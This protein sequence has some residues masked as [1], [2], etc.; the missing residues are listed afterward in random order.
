MVR[1]LFKN[2]LNGMLA[3][4]TVVFVTRHLHLLDKEVI[5]ARMADGKILQVEKHETMLE[6]DPDYSQ[7]VESCRLGEKKASTPVAEDMVALDEDEEL[8]GHE[9]ADELKSSMDNLVEPSKGSKKKGA[10]FVGNGL[11]AAGSYESLVSLLDQLDE[12]VNEMEPR[13]D[14]DDEEQTLY[15]KADEESMVDHNLNEKN[16]NHPTIQST[17]TKKDVKNRLVVRNSIAWHTYSDY[18]RATGG[19]WRFACLLLLFTLQATVSIFS[20]WWLTFWL[21]EGDGGNYQANANTTTGKEF[22][23]LVNPRLPLYASIYFVSFVV[24]IFTSLTMGL[25]FANSIITA[26]N[27]LHR[28]LL[29]KIINAPISFHDTIKMGSIINLFGHHIDVVDNLLPISLDSF[30]QRALLVIGSILIIIGTLYWLSL[31]MLLVAIAFVFIFR[32]YRRATYWLRRAEVRL[33]SPIGSWVEMTM[34]GKSTIKA[35]GYETRFIEQFHRKADQH[36]A[37]YFL[38]ESAVRW[39][40]IRIDVLCVF[41]STI[42]CVFV[43]IRLDSIGAAYAGLVITQSMMVSSVSSALCHH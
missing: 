25:V 21:N 24:V 26:A 14:E 12:E 38:S 28:K 2:V 29:Q 18:I 15:T 13:E 39:L 8:F 20:S 9:S 42:V 11:D 36:L 22:S 33:R 19:P 37:A 31:P 41:I 23:I 1:V 27:R 40:S 16:N 7:L 43:L 10:N 34:A 30:L 32:Y 5:V 4:K 6:N 17:K 35:F 3:K